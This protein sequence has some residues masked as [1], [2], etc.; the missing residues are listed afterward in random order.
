[1]VEI[2]YHIADIHIPNNISRHEEY[3]EVFEEV[4]KKLKKDNKEKL[5]VIKQY[6]KYFLIFLSFI[7]Q[8]NTHKFFEYFCEN[9][10]SKYGYENQDL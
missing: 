4:Y 10:K 7:L 9:C 5:I 8:F 1:M 3:K 2:I 6:K